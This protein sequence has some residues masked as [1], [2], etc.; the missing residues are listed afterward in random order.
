[1]R[2]GIQLGML[3]GTGIEEALDVFERLRA[4]AGLTACE[5]H[6]EASLYNAFWPWEDKALPVGLK[7]RS[8]L[9]VL[10][11]HLPFIDLYPVSPNPRVARYSLAVLKE[12]LSYAA[13]IHADY[14]VMHARSGVTVGTGTAAVW[15]RT[16]EEL[17]QMAAESGAKFCLEN[18]DDLPLAEL[19]SIADESD[20]IYACLDVGH[21]FERIYPTSFPWRQALI[22]NDRFSPL[23]FNLT[24]G[25]PVGKPGHWEESALPLLKRIG[26]IH[27][28]N[29][30]GRKAH[31]PL[32]RGKV[33]LGRLRFLSAAAGDTPLIVEAD[34]RS[35]GYAAIENDFV[36]LKEIIRS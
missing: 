34:Y 18:A 13:G 17:A 36:Y 1:M 29:H 5:I 27:L 19:R 8:T 24:Y 32:R 15:K 7:L 23:P 21:L 9:P 22:L 4:F 35:T 20:N 28:H 6:L 10:G 3:S 31:L 30:D 16:V 25:L 12:S 14:V 33:D 26:V 2:L 11:V